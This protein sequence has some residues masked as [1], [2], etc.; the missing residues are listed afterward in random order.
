[1][2]KINKLMD[3]I[4]RFGR[5]ALD[6]IVRVAR[7]IKHSITDIPRVKEYAAQSNSNK[8]RF[9]LGTA[10]LTIVGVFKRFFLVLLFGA[11]LALGIG[12]GFAVGL[13]NDQ[14]VPT[15]AQ[16]DKQ[17]NHPEQSSTLYYADM[18]KISDVRSDVKSTH[19]DKEEITPLV[20]QAVIATEDENFYEHSGVLPKSLIRAVFSELT[21][22]GVSTGGSTLT[23]QL[24]K[25]QFLTNQ[26]TWKRKVIEMFFAKKIEAHFTKDEILSAYLNVVPF[27]KNSSG[28]N[29][30]GIE[31]AAHGIFGKQIGELSLPE[32]A[33]I[34]GLPQS[35]SAYTPFTIT[36]KL[37]KDYSLGLK[38]KNIV[39][40]RMYRNGNITK[41]QYD[42]A[43][44]YD[45]TKDF[46][47][48]THSS[49]VNRYNN[50][51]YNL[52]TTKSV[53]LIANN[54]IKL[55]DEK[56]ATIKKDE[57]KYNQYLEK[58]SELV[59]QKGYHIKT[60]IDKNLYSIM[61][62]T[63]ANANLGT[64][65]TTVD[66]DDNLNKDVTV[67]E[68]AQNGSVMID[69]ETGR[70]IAFAGG[71]DFDSSQVNHAFN[72]YRSP[73]SSI[74]PYLVYGPAIENKLIGTKTAL[75]D[76]PTNYGSYIPTDY[77]QS[78]ENRFMNADEALRMSYNLPAV[79]L[80]NEVRKKTPVKKYMSELGFNIEN[81]EY[82]Q[83]GLALG[84]TKYG[85][86]VAQNAAAF[87]TFYNGG[88]RTEPYFI[89]QITDP[90]G[91]VIYKH[92]VKKKKVFS[93]GTA[94][95]MQNMLHEVTTEGTAAQLNYGLNFDT[96]K[97][98]GKT[99]TSNDYRDIWFNGSTPGVTISSWIGYDNFYG[100]TYNLSEN[101]SSIN[102]SLWSEM[103][104]QLYASNPKI[105]KLNEKIEKPS[106][107][108]EHTV[109]KQ[110]GTKGGTIEYDGARIHLTG[111]TVTSLSLAEHTPALS[112]EFSVGAK[113]KDY[114]SF[115]NHLSGKGSNYGT[116]L[117]YTGKTINT[118]E[119]VEDLFVANKYSPQEDDYYGNTNVPS[120]N[121]EETETEGNDVEAQTTGS[122]P[123]GDGD[124][125][126]E[127]AD[128]K[129]ETNT[130]G[131]AA[132]QGQTN[133][134]TT[135]PANNKN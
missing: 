29:I 33:F 66:H 120:K 78:V 125:T 39:L 105:F 37:K 9:Y 88:T 51:L 118:K 62:Q 103:V 58:A 59:T 44:K 90:S 111:Q 42:E 122:T 14:A 63:V 83:L 6:W 32:A 128:P 133:Q 45:L 18:S 114:E 121:E 91:N 52:V 116:R 72:T 80:F 64:E 17:I 132:G 74:K 8:S 12:V 47:K 101:A 77:G 30:A 16:L 57:A 82:D 10:Y 46:S 107:V 15:I 112:S 106:S 28:Q 69:N 93:K 27:G 36:G 21:G 119:N 117:Y 110:T 129:T 54:L 4:K 79:S 20:K 123:P 97:L 94:Y 1:M 85:F 11:F 60:T 19:V 73:G 65:H 48:P 134:Q 67:V 96:S 2:D 68:K 126:D 7:R 87:A 108:H 75:P 109:L 53:E 40:F 24:V 104:N 89:D 81:S 76:F 113:K 49:S 25:M 86:T 124:E 26:T 127:T 71:V 41:K 56:P 95:I 135:P 5:M 92:H 130:Q 43:K 102:M 61:S 34:A 55:D 31:E 3:Q 84:G 115:F 131:Q 50:Y 38:R 98:I 99:G 100:H 23:Q 22:V 70:V 35:P 13:L